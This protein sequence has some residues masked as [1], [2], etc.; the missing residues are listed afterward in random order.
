MK[1]LL[2]AVLI[3]SAFALTGCGLTISIEPSEP[4]PEEQFIAYVEK[5]YVP[6]NA[7]DEET[8]LFVGKALCDGFALDQIDAFLG[9]YIE[10]SE[11]YDEATREG[12]AHVLNAS[13]TYLCPEYYD[14][15]TE[16]L[17][18]R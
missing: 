2:S 15:V 4:S 18:Q 8:F 17:E 6:L 16:W 9:N 11:Q 1:K 12:S 3:L 7:E 10:V 14:D 5:N 13:V